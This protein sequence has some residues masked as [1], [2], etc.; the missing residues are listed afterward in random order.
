MGN[1]LYDMKKTVF[2]DRKPMHDLWRL[3]GDNWTNSTDIDNMLDVLRLQI[4]C[5]GHS[6]GF[7]ILPAHF[8]EQLT[9]SVESCNHGNQDDRTWKWLE[10]ISAQV[11]GEGKV[12]LMAVHL[13]TSMN[14]AHWVPLIFDGLQNLLFYG[15][16]L[17]PGAAVPLLI[18]SVYHS[19]AAFH[20][21]QPLRTIRLPV[22]TQQDGHS[23]SP[24]AVNALCAF[25]LKAPLVIEPC[26]VG[27]ER[28]KVFYEIV[29]ETLCHQIDPGLIDGDNN[30]DSDSTIGE[31]NSTKMSLGQR[32]PRRDKVE[33]HKDSNED[34]ICEEQEE[35]Y[36]GDKEE[37]AIK[38][39]NR[40][41]VVD[42]AIQLIEELQ[43]TDKIPTQ[44]GGDTESKE[45]RK[46][47]K[48]I[49]EVIQKERIIRIEEE[50][51]DEMDEMGEMDEMDGVDGVDGRFD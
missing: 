38:G 24:L 23:C 49:K 51:E 26:Q 6:E 48:E 31:K 35:D 40:N 43:I 4:K 29:L 3:L 44:I 21:L 13:G 15:D 17:D 47:L 2:P 22:T 34:D 16:S 11:F 42:A 30:Y 33:D 32:P 39:K 20:S 28:I 45:I 37:G 1:V 12:I 5:Q 19:W 14:M 46:K 10:K 27:F 50:D 7:I 8:T 25:S 9:S 36:D 41:V 18:R